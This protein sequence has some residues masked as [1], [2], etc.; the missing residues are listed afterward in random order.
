MGKNTKEFLPKRICNWQISTWKHVSHD[1]SLGKCKCKP[2]WNV[3]AQLSEWP[4]WKPVTTTN[5]DRDLKKL[6]FHTLLMEYKLLQLLCN[7]PIFSIPFA[8]K[9]IFSLSC[10]E[11]LL[12]NWLNRKSIWTCMHWYVPVPSISFY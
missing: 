7:Y 6:D 12:K 4:K 2:Q 5:S 11:Y 9:I 8:V 3:M 1:S 10:L